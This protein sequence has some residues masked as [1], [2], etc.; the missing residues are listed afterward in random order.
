MTEK[1]VLLLWEIKVRVK[2]FTYTKYKQF[3]RWTVLVSLLEVITQR[4]AVAKYYNIIFDETTDVSHTSQLSLSL[5]NVYDNSV[6]EDFVGFLDTHKANYS[7]KEAKCEPIITGV[8]LGQIVLKFMKDLGRNMANSVGI[9]CDSCSLNILDMR[10]AV[11][12]IQNQAIYS[13]LCVCKNHALNLSTS[14]CSTVQSVR[15]ATGCVQKVAAFFNMSAKCNYVLKNVLGHK[16]RGYCETHW[17]ERHESN[18][19]FQEDLPKI[20]E[21]LQIVSGWNDN[22]TASKVCYI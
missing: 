2:T 14:K 7:S 3:L 4:V 19:M 18:L 12:E 20:V 16:L 17:V 10:G 6:R 9:G 15:N 8:I 21:A 11:S 1:R 22:P 13:C 5:R